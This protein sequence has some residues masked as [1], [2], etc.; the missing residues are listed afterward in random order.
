MNV[1]EMNEIG[2]FIR[3]TRKE[4]GLRLE[5]LSDDHISTATISN[6]ERGVPH[7]NKDKVLYLMGK[8]DLDISEIPDMLEKD[9]ESLESMQVKFAAVE[10]LVN[11]G[12][13]QKALSL[14]NKIS[15]ESLSRHQATVHLLKGKCHLQNKDFRKGERELG[16]AIRLAYQDP[17]APKAN[18]EAES[19]YFLAFCR[20]VQKNWEQALSYIEKGLDAV[21]VNEGEHAQIRYNLLNAQ[22]VYLEK[23]GRTDEALHQLLLLWEDIDIISSKQVILEMY[24]LRAE[25]LV[26]LNMYQDAVRYAREGVQL[27]VNSNYYDE[28]FK[29]WSVL[30]RAYLDTAQ[31]DDASTCYEFLLEL[32]DQVEDRNEVVKTYFSLGELLM[33]KGEVTEAKNILKQALDLSEKYYDVALQAQ[34]HLLM[35]RLM[36][37]MSHMI[38]AI[39]YFQR[40]IQLAEKAKRF[41]LAY[42]SQFELAGC[43]EITGD[44]AE[45]NMTTAAMYKTKKQLVE[46]SGS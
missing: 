19:Y 34:A 16:E 39:Q 8:L 40:S 7:V 46:Q 10:A 23:L 31:Y 22:V 45:F 35:G 15:D 27:S 12:R 24:G 9:S 20:S 29:L 33:E 37:R 41:D 5:D 38:D 30:G 2:K 21:Q 42:R 11:L 25:L 26:S 36:K 4:R 28:M 18:L 1:L 3:K 13:T 32:G 17:Y 6:I 14:L 43:Y 44:Q